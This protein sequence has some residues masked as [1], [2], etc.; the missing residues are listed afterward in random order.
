LQQLT[1]GD[2][3][4][5]ASDVARHTPAPSTGGV[6]PAEDGTGGAEGLIDSALSITLDRLRRTL[7]G[8]VLAGLVVGGRLD[9]LI[10]PAADR[11]AIR[12][13]IGEL[14]R[15]G[16]QGELLGAPDGVLEGWWGRWWTTGDDRTA[17]V[18]HAG[19]RSPEADLRLEAAG[20]DLVRRLLL[21]DDGRHRDRVRYLSATTRS[22]ADS[23]ALETIL[24]SIVEAAT[25]LLGGDSGDMLLWDREAG[26][27][28]VVA[29]SSFPPEMLGFSAPFG[30][31]LSSQAILAGRTLMVEDYGRYD[32][33]I[34]ALDRYDFGSV[35]CSP[36]MVRGEAIGAINVHAR[37]RHLHF[38]PGA[39]DLLA[40][41]AGNAAI[42]I[43]QARRYEKESALAADL[44]ESNGQLTRLLTM[45]QRLAEL[46]LLDGGPEGIARLLAEDL[47]RPVVIQD[48]LHRRVAAAAPD[49]GSSWQDLLRRPEIG[50]TGRD[51]F[52][53]AVRVG[54][55]VVGHL[56]LSSDADLGPIDRALVDAATTG[57]ALAFAKVRAALE[58]EERLRGEAMADLLAGEYPS[59]A[60]ISAR[61]ARLGYDLDEPRG[62]LV[63]RLPPGD[64]M[65]GH[66]DPDRHQR[67]LRAVRERLAVRAPR[68]MAAVQGGSIVVLVPAG[69][70]GEGD[71]SGL[72]E[73]LRD[74]LDPSTAGGRVTIAI[75]HGCRRPGD[76]AP[77]FRMA[78]ETVDLLLRLGRE[79]AIVT[80][81]D[82]G[83]YGLLLRSSA[84]EEL[85]EFATR[86]LRPLLDPGRA[87]GAEL[88][89]TLRIYLEEDRVQRRAAARCFVHVNT[90][91]YRVHRIQELLG[92][93]L[94]DPATV[95]DLTLALRILDLLGTG[96]EAGAAG[97]GSA[98]S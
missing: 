65:E 58:V 71:L 24:S 22:V 67:A 46:V 84:R 51:P 52:T 85:A 55:E 72:A 5:P 95:F 47:G 88:L 31:G 91:V 60:A 94:A 57:V 16:D 79:G 50:G 86:T 70:G 26:R 98:L 97:A 43:D 23:A 14:P 8:D 21:A 78:R 15:E 48:Q 80:T 92:I 36:L 64:A 44:A 74:S 33:R 17:L 7:A 66:T 29:V 81:A 73:D 25:S 19:L 53:V 61:A 12:T 96:P 13:A 62:L 20:L 35:M 56:L 10:G 39:A 1:P 54:T 38:P 89:R 37:G 69:R 11:P 41:F 87:N 2:V 77:A 27:L 45:Q 68:S 34:R 4:A 3:L 83:P 6:R 30:E 42:A 82:L 49:G 93:D 76:Y 63:V 59:D 75:A 28:V 32:H 18:L 9:R 90:I 40:A